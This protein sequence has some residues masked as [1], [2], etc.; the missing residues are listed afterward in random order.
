MSTCAVNVVTGELVC[1][2][3]PFAPRPCAPGVVCEPVCPKVHQVPTINSAA[4]VLMVFLLVTITA[5]LN[6][7][8][9]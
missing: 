9:K 8:R 1:P 4:L 7:A 2:P 5:I 3:C 6:K